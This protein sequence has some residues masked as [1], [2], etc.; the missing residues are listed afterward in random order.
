VEGEF[1]K[2]KV[3]CA[4]CLVYA[5]NDHHE[6]LVVWNQL[7]GMGAIVGVPMV[8]MGVFNEVISPNERRG[9]SEVSQGMRDLHNLFQ[10]LQLV[11]M[12][13]DQQFTWVRKM[14]LAKLIGS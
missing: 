13:I 8:L 10:D 4:I 6:R 3:R 11:D 9:G 14:Q 5:P 1:I 7:M 12:E 2:A